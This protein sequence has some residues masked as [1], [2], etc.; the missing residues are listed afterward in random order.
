[1]VVGKATRAG[2]Y[3]PGHHRPVLVIKLFYVIAVVIIL[4]KTMFIK[5]FVSTDTNSQQ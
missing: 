4:L 1:M 2:C 3:R 5:F